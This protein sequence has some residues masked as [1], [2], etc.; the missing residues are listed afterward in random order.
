MEDYT[1]IIVVSVFVG[2]LVLN[3]VA[4]L[5]WRICTE[6]KRVKKEKADKATQVA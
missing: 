2:V 5:V 3:I 4:L 1:L 6:M